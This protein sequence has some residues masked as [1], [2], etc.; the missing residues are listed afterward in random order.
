MSTAGT[1]AGRSG[2]LRL[3]YCIYWLILRIKL[4]IAW[5]QTYF[6]LPIYLRLKVRIPT[7]ALQEERERLRA[8]RKQMQRVNMNM[9]RNSAAFLLED[10]MKAHEPPDFLAPDDVYG[11]FIKDMT[12]S[13]GE[14]LTPFDP[15][16]VSC[17]F[18]ASS[19][20]NRERSW[21]PCVSDS[22][23]YYCDELGYTI[24]VGYKSLLEFI[25]E[26]VVVGSAVN[27]RC[28]RPRGEQKREWAQ[29]GYAI[30]IDPQVRFRDSESARLQ[31]QSVIWDTA[32]SKE[33][34]LSIAREVSQ[35]SGLT[36]C[37]AVMKEMHFW[38]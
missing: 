1:P 33:E 2:S 30:L 15:E 35:Y 20:S 24:S 23:N 16:A 18:F 28:P 11:T 37:V 19:S 21:S 7:D 26:E 31:Q 5:V 12:N 38:H 32:A 4:C 17:R 34:A 22:F 8:L 3:I 25:V 14:L 27:L 29:S 36:S 6:Y 13:H 9:A 10:A